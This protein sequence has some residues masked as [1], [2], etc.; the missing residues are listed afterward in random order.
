M[1]EESA[2]RRSITSSVVTL[3]IPATLSVSTRSE[4]LV[5]DPAVLRGWVVIGRGVVVMSE[6]TVGKT[7]TDS[8]CFVLSVG[9]S[10]TSDLG[11]SIDGATVETLA[12]VMSA[13]AVIVVLLVLVLATVVG[14]AWVVLVVVVVVVVVI[15]VVVVVVVVVDDVSSVVVVVVCEIVSRCDV[16]H[17]KDVGLVTLFAHLFSLSLSFLPKGKTGDFRR[18]TQYTQ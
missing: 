7:V 15:G 3:L 13:D 5:C 9:S 17:E 6:G 8:T 10:V 2:K 12:V 1:A 18:C 4:T 11:D 16:W 14:A